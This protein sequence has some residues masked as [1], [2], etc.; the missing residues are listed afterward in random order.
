MPL[1]LRQVC[2]R[3]VPKELAQGHMAGPSIPIL[4]CF[5][6]LP[7]HHFPSSLW[8][9]H[10]LCCPLPSSVKRLRPSL[11][12]STKPPPVYSD[13]F[14]VWTLYALSMMA[15]EFKIGCFLIVSCIGYSSLQLVRCSLRAN[16]ALG[17]HSYGK[18]PSPQVA[19]NKCDLLEAGQRQ[20][21]PIRVCA[22]PSL[23]PAFL[24]ICGSPLLIEPV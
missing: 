15:T 3:Q 18:T 23:L 22:L 21:S 4:F 5:T 14:L 19:V 2:L 6:L 10:S 16:P 12:P 24:T 20:F 1:E 13:V 9:A 17:L 8:P 7:P 11:T